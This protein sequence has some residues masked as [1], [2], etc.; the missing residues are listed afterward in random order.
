[1]IVVQFPKLD[2]DHVEILITEEIFIFVDIWLVLDIEHTFE[3][4]RLLEL[5]IGHF[6]VILFICHEEHPIDHTE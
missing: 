1:M 3:Y 6:V 2:V 5:S 4:L